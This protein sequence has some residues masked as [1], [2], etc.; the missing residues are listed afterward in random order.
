M[1]RTALLLLIASCAFAADN[2]A[3]LI[4]AAKR[5][6]TEKVA[7]LL[8]KGSPV[9]PADKDGRTPL[10]L[11]AMHGHADTVAA[12]LQH[13]AKADLR[14]RVGWTAYGLAVFSTASHRDAVLDLLPARPP[15]R[16]MLEVKWTPENLVTSCFLRPAQL[17]EQ[18]AAVQPD[19]QVAAALRDAVLASGKR[20]VELVSEGGDAT[21]RLTVHPGTSCVQQQSADNITELIDIRLAA[22]DGSVLLEKTVGGGFKGL[23]A[24]SVTSPAQYGV[25]FEESAKSHGSEICAATL[26]AWLKRQ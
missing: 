16:L 2:G 15:L 24:R 6:Q 4:L 26:E 12:L 23:H 13:G 9:D 18:V 8:S 19:A 17:R 25:T 1:P 11:A 20:F 22:G 14:D 3:D 5:G 21:L 7:A 10:M